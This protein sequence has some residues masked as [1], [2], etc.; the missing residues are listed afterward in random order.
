[1]W[2][3]KCLSHMQTLVGQH[4]K[5]QTKKRKLQIAAY[6]QST[7]TFMLEKPTLVEPINGQIRITPVSQTS[8]EITE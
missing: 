6:P 5:H 7:T 3:R 2:R 4:A 8:K 1:M